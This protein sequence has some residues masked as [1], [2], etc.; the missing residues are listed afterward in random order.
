MRFSSLFDPFHLLRKTL[1]DRSRHPNRDLLH[2]LHQTTGRKNCL[3]VSLKI[4][5]IDP[6]GD[7]GE[8]SP[9]L[10]VFDLRRQELPRVHQPGE[11]P[12][13]LLRDV[14]VFLALRIQDQDGVA[15]K[16][17]PL[18]LRSVSMSPT[19]AFFSTSGSFRKLVPAMKE[20]NRWI[21]FPAPGL[22]P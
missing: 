22:A 15:V 5:Q 3:S 13:V 8:G 2:L 20:S 9:G 18:S 11:D 16:P 1:Q 4:N 17:E 14:T 12:V 6:D 10:D 19:A 7:H 21:W